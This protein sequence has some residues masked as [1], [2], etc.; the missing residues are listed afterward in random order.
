MTRTITNTDDLIDIRDVIARFEELEPDLTNEYELSK[1]GEDAADS[2]RLSFDD[3]TDAQ[4]EDGA[5]AAEY[6]RLKTLLEEC[7]GNG[8]D[9]QWRGD[10]YPITLIRYSYTELYAR[11]FADDI[12]AVNR[13][14]SWPYTCIDWER[15]TRE[16]LM[17]YTIIEFEGV[18]YYTR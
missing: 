8:G 11:D 14:V 2:P 3:W 1:A 18:T 5:E 15:A 17:D 12:G 16:F 7:C 9:E 6:L 13:D 4:A 10:W